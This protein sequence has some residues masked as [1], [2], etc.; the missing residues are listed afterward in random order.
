MTKKQ[1]EDANRKQKQAA[2]EKQAIRTRELEVAADAVQ[3]RKAKVNAIIAETKARKANES[4][5]KQMHA[6]CATL[7]APITNMK[8]N[9]HYGD[10]PELCRTSFEHAVKEVTNLKRSTSGGGW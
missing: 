4:L 6:K 10:L 2:K 8:D 7:A 5:A 9:P 1:K 3:E